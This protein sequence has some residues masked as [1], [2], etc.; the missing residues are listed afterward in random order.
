MAI[1]IF[2]ATGELRP[3]AAF[4]AV[5]RAPEEV[6][7]WDRKNI[8]AGNAQILEQVPLYVPSFRYAIKG[9]NGQ[10]SACRQRLESFRGGWC[11]A[12]HV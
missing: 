6:Q 12:N 5:A 7:H 3:P 8:E 11:N 1:R 2:I 10:I 9:F 4:S